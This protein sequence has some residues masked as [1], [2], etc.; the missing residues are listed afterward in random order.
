MLEQK[1]N[2]E[3]NADDNS[4]SQPIAKPHVVRMALVTTPLVVIDDLHV[5]CNFQ[6]LFESLVHCQKDE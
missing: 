5:E 4:F 6:K 2:N 3:Q 1:Q